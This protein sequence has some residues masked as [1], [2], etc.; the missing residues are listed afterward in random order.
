MVEAR[1]EQGIVRP[2]MRCVV[3]PVGHE[4]TI[5]AVVSDSNVWAPAGD[6]VSLKLSGVAQSHLGNADLFNGNVLCPILDP[7]PAV[8]KLKAKLWVVHLCH[9]VPVL[10]SGFS[11]SMHVH[12]ATVDC[13]ILKLF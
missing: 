11:A 9:E 13:E 8:S 4:C 12:S 3:A 10:S 5:E 2:N 1:V 6:H 7:L